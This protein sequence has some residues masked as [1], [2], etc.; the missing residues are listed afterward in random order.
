MIGEV[1]SHYKILSRLGEGGMGVVYKAEDLRLRRNVALKFLPP[2][3]TTDSDARIR[4]VEEAQAAS[5]LDH[6]NI[7]VIHEIDETNDGRSFICMALYDGETLKQRIERGPLGVKETVRIGLQVADGLRRAHEAGIIHRDIKPANLITTRDGMVKIVDFGL[8]KLTGN[9]VQ[10]TAR[11]RPGTAAYMSPE[12]IQNGVVDARSDLFS[13][14]VV[15]YEMVTGTRPFAAGH[16]AALFYSIVYDKPAS[17]C[18]LRPGSPEGLAEIIM[19]LLQK[20][21]DRRYGSAAEVRDAL[22]RIALP[23]KE[24]GA[25][26]RGFHIIMEHKYIAGPL[27]IAVFVLGIILYPRLSVRSFRIEPAS[28]V[29]VADLEN[30][31]RNAVFDHSLT[32]AMKVSLRQSP[33]FNILPSSRIAETLK[34][35]RVPVNTPFAENIAVAAARREGIGVVVAGGI[36]PVG[37]SFVLSCKIIDANAGETVQMFRREVTRIED[38]LPAMDKLCEDIREALGESERHISENTIRLDRVTTPSLDALELYS[39]GNVLE[40]E[41][42]YREAA[43]LKAQAVLKDTMFAIAV[44]DLSYIYRKLGEDSLALHYHSRVLPLIDRVTDRERFYIL[45]VYYGPSFELD[46]QRAFE[47]IQQLVVRYPNSSEGYATL[48]HLAMFVG[49]YGAALE[50]DGKALSIDSVYKGTVFNNMGYALALSGNAATAIEYFRQSKI[51]RQ[52][53]YSIDG[54]IAQCYWMMGKEDSAEKILTN[55]LTVGDPRTRT[56]A[57]SQLAALYYFQG[58][59]G[60]AGKACRDAIVQL[61]N[62]QRKGEESYFHYL[63]GRIERDRGDAHKYAGEMRQAEQTS[64]SPFAE[65]P[66][67]AA[68]YAESGKLADAARVLRHIENVRSSDPYFVRRR[69]AYLHLVKGEIL[70]A[71]QQNTLASREFGLVERLHSADPFYLLAQK[72]IAL[73]ELE[74]RDTTG[75]RR[76]SGILGQRG[77]V[78]FALI[79]ALRNSGPWIRELWPDIDLEL[80]RFYLRNNDTTAAARY[81]DECLRCWQYA[82][83]GFIGGREALRLKDKINRL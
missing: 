39:R 58:R 30:S 7:G 68:S 18:A 74:S 40:G 27:L 53:Y 9:V 76:L 37:A 52:Q 44:S 83:T 4:F 56:L 46:Y 42:K 13:L 50:A 79:L 70:L 60:C 38:V 35:M 23:A 19:R 57:Y 17:P 11:A 14:G 80:A 2:E 5:A 25:F 75:E 32:E 26:T 69:S 31:T 66:L 65:L 21:P 22:S 3:L 61:Q 71:K 36:H 15:L 8:A 1:I 6:P 29:I 63:L 82:D 12:Q 62:E 67:I 54:Y 10:T 49:N 47:N 59:L 72:G 34:R 73:G 33:H 28:Y 64:E 51:I 45:A 78:V 16:E 24:P 81:L 41:G 48:G 43:I 20:D 55:L 77:E